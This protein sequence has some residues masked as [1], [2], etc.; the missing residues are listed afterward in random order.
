MKSKNL[1]LGRRINQVVSIIIC[2]VLIPLFI[3]FLILPS[4]L[5]PDYNYNEDAHL[6]LIYT[7]LFIF[8]IVL[9]IGINAIVKRYIKQSIE[10]N[11]TI[12]QQLS[13]PIVQHSVSN[14]DRNLKLCSSCGEEILDKTG[15]FCSKCGAP[16]K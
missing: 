2:A 9:T 3:I 4:L 8:F 7:V 12:Q 6:Y 15:E 14:N 10:E 5:I 16:I 11:V 13:Q 1:E